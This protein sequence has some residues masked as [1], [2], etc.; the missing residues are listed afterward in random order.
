MCMHV[1]ITS[2]MSIIYYITPEEVKEFQRLKKTSNIRP[3]MNINY[4]IQN[5][6]NIY[7]LNTLRNMAIAQVQTS[8]FYLSDMDVWPSRP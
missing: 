5:D 4:V 8:H 7:P 6:P 2:P 1:V 3:N